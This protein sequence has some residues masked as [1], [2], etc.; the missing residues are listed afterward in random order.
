MHSALTGKILALSLFWMLSNSVHADSP[1]QPSTQYQPDEVV[2]I[3]IEALG[4]NTE[5]QNDDGIATVYR[6]A[7]PGNRAN[8]GPLSRFTQHDQAWLWRHAQLC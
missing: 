4:A 7:S 5:S 1:L 2:Q 3:V 8:T 6:F